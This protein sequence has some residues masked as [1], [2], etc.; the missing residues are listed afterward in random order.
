MDK[1]KK[2]AIKRMEMLKLH[3]NTIK[4]FIEEDKLNLTERNGAL[5]WL[6][7]EQKEKVKRFEQKHNALVYHVIHSITEFGD[8]LDLLYVT[9]P[10]EEW[11]MQHQDIEENT[12][13]SY[14][15]VNDFDSTSEFG[16]I[17]IRSYIGG[18]IRTD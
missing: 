11:K 1:L 13:Y 18:V 10:E 16:R 12:P 7:D 6:N 15:I 9:E 17:G 8:L 3:P 5:F 4:D 2:E 14:C